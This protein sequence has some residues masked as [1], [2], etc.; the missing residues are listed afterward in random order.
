MWG[1][2]FAVLI[3]SGRGQSLSLTLLF[4]DIPWFD[5]RGGIQRCDWLKNSHFRVNPV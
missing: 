2:E 4:G 5:V 3:L 1:P